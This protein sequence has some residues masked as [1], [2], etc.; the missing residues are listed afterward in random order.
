MS[1]VR[2]EDLR[3]G[4]MIGEFCASDEPD[5]AFLFFFTSDAQDFDN[6]RRLIQVGC[7]TVVSVTP[8]G[9]SNSITALCRDMTLWTGTNRDAWAI[10][11]KR[12]IGPTKQHSEPQVKHPRG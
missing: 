9:D 8:D 11:I 7:A 5:H 10:L 3:P 4:D 12:R 2:F 6:D 1:W